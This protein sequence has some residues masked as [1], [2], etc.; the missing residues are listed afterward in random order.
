MKREKSKPVRS[1]G[2]ETKEHPVQT[3]LALL[4]L[5]VPVGISWLKVSIAPLIL[6]VWTAAALL[7]IA[8][9]DMFGITICGGS[10]PLACWLPAVTSL[11]PLYVKK[12]TAKR[13]ARRTNVDP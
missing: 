7:V 11:L 12:R 3:A 6:T 13:L 9:A 5:P 10:L 1:K 2:L 8:L 4:W